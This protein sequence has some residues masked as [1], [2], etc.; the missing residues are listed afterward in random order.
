MLVAVL[1]A[2]QLDASSLPLLGSRPRAPGAACRYL[3]VAGDTGMRRP[4]ASHP[5]ESEAYLAWSW[6]ASL[7]QPHLGSRSLI[8]GRLWRG[9]WIWMVWF[10][11]FK[12][13]NNKKVSFL[14]PCDARCDPS[15][16]VSGS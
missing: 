10:V 12:N 3:W 13:M 4:E 9:T 16:L 14:D 15:V 2:C 11:Q 7:P 5:G 1:D 8:C 6:A